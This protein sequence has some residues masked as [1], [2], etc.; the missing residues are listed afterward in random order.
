MKAKAPV[1]VSITTKGMTW[2]LV[3]CLF[4][5]WLRHLKL[6][7]DKKNI[8]NSILIDLSCGLSLTLSPPSTTKV[9][10]ANSLDQ[11]ETSSY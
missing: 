1:I 2:H 7:A 4:Y 3:T 8:A 10:Y 9:P 11:D 5:T 6:D